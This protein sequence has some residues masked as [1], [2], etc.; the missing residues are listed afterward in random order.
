MKRFLLISAIGAVFVGMVVAGAHGASKPTNVIV[1]LADDMG[2]GDLG[3][4]GQPTIKTPHFDRMAESGMRFT[5]AYSGSTV[6]APSR[7]VLMTGMHIGHARIRGNG[8][9]ELLPDDMTLAKLMKKAGYATGCFGKWGIG[10]PAP[11]GDDP[12]R[13]GFD[14]FYGYVS[15]N[16]AHNFYPEFMVHNGNEVKLRN[17]LMDEFRGDFQANMKT[18][19]SGV[20]KEKID[21]APALIRE[22]L[23][24]FIDDSKDKPF[25]V[26]YSPNTP[27]ANNEGSRYGLDRGMEV[28][29][30]GEF[31]DRD[32]PKHEKGF[33]VMIRD[34]DDDVGQIMAKLKEYGIDKN[35]LFIFSS[36]NGPH[37]EGGHL[38][39]YFDSNGEKRGKK[40]D[41]YEGGVRVPMIAWQPGAVPAG[42]LNESIVSFQDFMATLAELTAQPCPETDGISMLP[43]LSGEKKSD[44]DRSLYWEFGEGI[45]RQAILKGNWKLIRFFPR[46][47]KNKKRPSP[48]M[49]LYNVVT[50]PS[51]EENVAGRYPERVS[52]LLQEMRSMMDENTLIRDPEL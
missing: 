4:Y 38:V 20:A 18:F 21:Y 9:G 40:R 31:A 26:Y 49:E 36:D 15:M 50:D 1:M 51:E 19:G 44:T 46:A 13:N 24:E 27:H 41:L 39:D 8:P 37:Q 42:T 45:T 2:F 6:C 47:Q 5:R 11:I 22:K 43:Y 32:W 52:Q 3:C 28:P 17:E 16:H 25:F 48:Y 30:F 29:D 14:E 23:F 7:C 35:T 33:A 34:L 10:R 12:N